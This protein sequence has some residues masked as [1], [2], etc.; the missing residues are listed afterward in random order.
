M[1]TL[2]NYHFQIPGAVL[3][4]RE[5]FDPEKYSVDTSRGSE[6]FLGEGQ[7]G[8]VYKARLMD[9]ADETAHQP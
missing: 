4:S 5:G 6:D 1:S 7:F 2:T 3:R 8:R 9:S